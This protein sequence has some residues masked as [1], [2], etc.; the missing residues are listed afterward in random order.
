MSS[1]KER[2]S[3]RQLVLNFLAAIA[4]YGVSLCVRFLLTPYIVNILGPEAYGFIG[5][6]GEILGYS[7]L[8]TVALNSMAGRFITIS[9]SSGNI[10]KAR[11]YFTSVIFSNIF[12]AVIISFAFFIVYFY[13]E[14]FIKIPGHLIRD[15]KTLYMLMGVNNIIGL[16]MGSWGV[17]LFIKN[18]LDISSVRNIIGN[19][20]Q[21]GVLFLLF[22]CCRPHIWYIGLA[23]LMMS[24][25]CNISNWHIAR[26]LTPDLQLRK[27]DYDFSLV[28]ELIASGAWNLLSRLG[29]IMSSGM[30]L[31][32]ANV[33]IGSAAMGYFAITKNIP[34]LILSLFQTISTVFAPVFTNYYATGEKE[35]LVHEFRKSIRILSFMVSM[36]LAVMYIWGDSFYSLWLPLEDAGHLQLLT[37]LGT[38]ALPYTLPLESLWQIFT[39]TNKLKYSTL[40]SFLDSFVVF[41][42]VMSSM[43]LIESPEMR[44]II[45]ASARS[46][47]GLVRGFVFLPIYGAYCLSLRKRCFYGTIFHSLLSCFICILSS[48]LLRFFICVDSWL[49]LIMA[50]FA[51]CAVCS[52]INFMLLLSS[53]DRTYILEKLRFKIACS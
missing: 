37:I 47:C 6:T 49:S 11:K 42:I 32:I 19:L 45:L 13:L 10:E 4:T 27:A 38:F 12:L 22:F 20:I 24:L 29:R 26:K 43:C 23:A 48:Y 15:V 53:S 17:A 35:L 31:I 25:Y 2:S 41:G 51:T 44:L 40:F 50:S 3:N 30:D 9:Y 36:P 46:L 14:S 28:R 39:I 7:L 52:G 1:V 16:V 33:C 34:F 21:G 8:L 5:L 18:R